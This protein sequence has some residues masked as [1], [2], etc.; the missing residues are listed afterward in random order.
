M[1]PQ[2]A[3]TMPQSAPISRLALVTLLASAALA[4]ACGPPKKADA[5]PAYRLSGP[6]THDN[7]TVFLIHGDETVKGKN[8]LTLDEALAQKKAVVHETKQVNELSVE[9]LSEKEEVF[10]Q[11]G[12]I[13]KGGQQDRT[14]AYDLVVPPKSGKVPLKSFCVEA[15]RWTRRGGES[16]ERFDSSATNLPTNSQK[17]A[18]RKAMKQEEVW[19]KVAEAQRALR[20][21]VG[22]EVQAAQSQSSLQLTLE[23]K[24][25]L[26]AIDGYVKKLLSSPE[27]KK[28]VIGYA[29]CINGKVNNAD[30]YGNNALFLKLW[31]KLLKASAVEA[32]AEL[33]K[34]KKFDAPKAEAVLTFLTDVEKGKRGEKKINDRLL[35]VERETDR[36]CLF[37]T[38][39]RDQKGAAVR[40]SYVAK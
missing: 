30:V 6:F 1:R 20:S 17:L 22:A 2:E 26:E 27:G 13:V 8:F 4:L 40:R 36:G 24:K 25:V 5:P 10:I 12:D 18:A 9:N 21:N 14:I 16:V 35:Q 15:G 7:L 38:C 34:G 29:V 3:F 37:I 39:P 31:P 11:A 19:E 33:K 28:D 23:H 32:V